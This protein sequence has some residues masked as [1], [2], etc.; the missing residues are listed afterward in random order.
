MD[1]RKLCWLLLIA[2]TAS[3]AFRLESN[4]NSVS[5]NIY[6]NALLMGV[7]GEYD[8]NLKLLEKFTG[9]KIYFR[10]NTIIIKGEK[11]ANTKVKNAIRFLVEKFRTNSVIENNDVMSALNKYMTENY[12]QS[13][14]V[15]SLEEIIKTPKR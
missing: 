2:V 7:V 11:S 3:T 13:T 1:F 4:A 14:E 6:D 15:Q 10:G 9:S 12:K 5:I 8:N